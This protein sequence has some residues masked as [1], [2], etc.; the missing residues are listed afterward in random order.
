MILAETSDVIATGGVLSM[1]GV[2]MAEF[3]RRSRDVDARS[4]ATT[5]AAVDAANARAQQALD[6]L[7]ECR[8]ANLRLRQGRRR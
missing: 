8:A 5:K 3:V 6:D 2:I 1:L 7:A 4:D